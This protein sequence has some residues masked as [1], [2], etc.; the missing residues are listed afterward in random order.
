VAERIRRAA[1][2]CAQFTLLQGEEE[3]D[4]VRVPF[5]LRT[6][7]LLQKRDDEGQSFVLEVNGTR[8][9]CKGANWIHRTALSRGSRGNV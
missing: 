4:Q 8:I 6:I 5:A 1:D 3:V 7:S 9:F 2:V